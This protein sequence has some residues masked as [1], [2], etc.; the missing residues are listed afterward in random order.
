MTKRRSPVVTGATV[1]QIEQ[2]IARGHGSVFIAE[3]LRVPLRQV[4]AVRAALDAIN[5][6]PDVEHPG[7]KSPECRLGLRSRRGRRV[8]LQP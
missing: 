5:N 7:R 3:Q 8:E 4:L 1:E 2:A 6:Q